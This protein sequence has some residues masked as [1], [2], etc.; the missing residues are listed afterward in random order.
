MKKTEGGG[1]KMALDKTPPCLYPDGFRGTMNQVLSGKYNRIIEQL[2][3]QTAKRLAENFVTYCSNVFNETVLSHGRITWERIMPKINIMLASRIVESMYTK[4]QDD[5]VGLLAE[6]YIVQDSSDSIKSLIWPYE[7]RK[8]PAAQKTA[9][10]QAPP[11]PTVIQGKRKLRIDQPNC[12]R[13]QVDKSLLTALHNLFPLFNSLAGD[14]LKMEWTNHLTNG[15]REAMNTFLKENKKMQDLIETSLIKGGVAKLLL[16]TIDN[17]VNMHCLPDTPAKSSI[18]SVQMV[19]LYTDRLRTLT[20]ALNKERSCREGVA[21]FLRQINDSFITY[22]DNGLA[23]TELLTEFEDPDKTP[24]GVVLLTPALKRFLVNLDTIQPPVK[25][26]VITKKA[27]ISTK[28]SDYNPSVALA[29]NSIIMDH[30]HCFANR[31]SIDSESETKQLDIQYMYMGDKKYAVYEIRNDK[32]DD[33]FIERTGLSHEFTEDEVHFFGVTFN[34]Q[35]PV[36]GGSQNFP[37]IPKRSFF[38]GSDGVRCEIKLSALKEFVKKMYSVP[39]KRD[40]NTLMETQLRRLR[41][42]KIDISEKEAKQLKMEFLVNADKIFPLHEVDE[43][44]LI[45]YPYMCFSPMYNW[46]VF[47][48]HF[49]TLASNIQFTDRM[50]KVTDAIILNATDWWKNF[51]RKNSNLCS[52]LAKVEDVESNELSPYSQHSDSTYKELGISKKHAVKVSMNLPVLFDLCQ[53]CPV[54]K[55][56]DYKDMRYVE[57]GIDLIETSS[58]IEIPDFIEKIAI[59]KA[60]LQIL[61]SIGPACNA[62]S[63]LG[64]GCPAGEKSDLKKSSSFDEEADLKQYDVNHFVDWIMAKNMLPPFGI[65]LV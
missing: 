21:W 30:D 27:L 63:L 51:Q 37:L 23:V 46:T 32:L 65:A 1:G 7:Y 22:C 61:L 41:R 35:S 18:S 16:D 9:L 13:Y 12:V 48:D 60:I 34:T 55:G 2:S 24:V 42:L 28:L 57:N 49:A 50:P 6:C 38:M 44:V 52:I 31:K 15:E 4:A 45:M 20:C 56:I 58:K 62:P 5:T 10:G 8:I 59:L 33:E 47:C 39:H 29:G 25:I 26:K 36:L 19:K 43:D 40:I 54:L 11:E 53:L 3:D 14:T 17:A 64:F